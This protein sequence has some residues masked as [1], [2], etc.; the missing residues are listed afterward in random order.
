M[1]EGKRITIGVLIGNANSM[2]SVNT[3]QGIRQAAKEAGV[4]TVTF[5]GVHTE[6]KFKE[7]Y[8]EDISYDYQI[9][10]IFDYVDIANVDALIISYGEI[11][12]FLKEAKSRH[13]LDKYVIIPKILL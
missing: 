1:P 3:L 5:L 2:H 7:F 8:D 13:F 12:V 4:N 11:V 10:T 9:M 6:Y